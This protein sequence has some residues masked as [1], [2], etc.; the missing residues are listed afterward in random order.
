M[1]VCLFVCLL[2]CTA[3]TV[4]STEVKLGE[5][6]DIDHV[7]VRK[8]LKKSSTSPNY[9]IGQLSQ[10]WAISRPTETLEVKSPS[11]MKDNLKTQLIYLLKFFHDVSL[12]G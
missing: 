11:H 4:Y 1:S 12:I 9:L 3:K 2:P 10:L 7:S 8:I 6:L 5:M